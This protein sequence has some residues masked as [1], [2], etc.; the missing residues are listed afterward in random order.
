M[1]HI[2]STRWAENL[3]S[4]NRWQL[5]V[6]FT[7]YDL[8]KNHLKP[9]PL[10]GGGSPPLAPGLQGTYAAIGITKFIFV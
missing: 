6:Y 4:P 9:S 2:F 10:R 8:P 3:P 5:S 7:P 1:L